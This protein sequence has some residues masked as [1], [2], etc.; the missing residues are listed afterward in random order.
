M[1]PPAS[2]VV[3]IARPPPSGIFA[4]LIHVLLSQ[5]LPLCTLESL[6]LPHLLI[7]L[8]TLCFLF[9]CSDF[10]L[11]CSYPTTFWSL[12]WILTSVFAVSTLCSDF[13][14]LR[15]HS[16]LSLCSLC[17]NTFSIYYDLY[18]NL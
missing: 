12:P 10:G 8:S 18:V 11:L 15:L 14:H 16:G 7:F 2:N 9:S 5:S 6:L 3:K 17:F 1:L 13:S 4:S